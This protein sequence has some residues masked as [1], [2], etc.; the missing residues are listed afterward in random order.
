M[1]KIEL[2][3]EEDMRNSVNY[4]WIILSV[5]VPFVIYYVM[6][7]MSKSVDDHIRHKVE[8]YKNLNIPS[9]L[10]KAMED[11][12][13]NTIVYYWIFL[14]SGIFEFLMGLIFSINLQPLYIPMPVILALLIN[15]FFLVILVDAI[16]K[17]LYVHQ[18]IEEDINKSMNIQSNLRTFKKRNGLSFMI[19]SIITL[20]IYAYI[21]LALVTKEYLNHIEI[22]Y[23]I[24]EEMK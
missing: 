11:F 14:I 6:Y 20:T 7:K 18:L 1:D 3:R 22:D 16:S 10:L 19:L 17:R 23:R 24:L 5:F 9:D 15:F 21:Y 2:Y 12:P 13:V 8:I 4:I